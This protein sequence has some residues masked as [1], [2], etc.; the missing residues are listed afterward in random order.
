M[1]VAVAQMCQSFGFARISPRALHTLT[2]VLISYVDEIGVRA[3]QYAELAHRTECNFFDIEAS[4]N[5]LACAI[6]PLRTFAQ[7]SEEIPF[8]HAPPRFPDARPALPDS[9]PKSSTPMPAYVPAFYPR[10]PASHTFVGTAVYPRAADDDVRRERIKQRR[11]IEE[12]LRRMRQEQLRAAGMT[13]TAVLNYDARNPFLVPP[14]HADSAAAPMDITIKKR[15]LVLPS[16]A[17]TLPDTSEVVADGAT[18][19]PYTAS[20]PQ[21]D[22][23]DMIE[24]RRRAEDILSVAEQTTARPDQ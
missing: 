21:Y 2:D 20:D 24:R 3:R 16:S 7:I 17:P 10:F 8:A 6:A 23:Q 13:E 18:S 19:L 12:S 9:T 5:D 14:T 15:K 11:D 22:E 4:L 1:R